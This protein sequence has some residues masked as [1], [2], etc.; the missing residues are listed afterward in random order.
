MRKNLQTACSAC[1]CVLQRELGI[2]DHSD[3]DRIISS[4]FRRI[5]IDLDHTPRQF[6]GPTNRWKIRESCA[7]GQHDIRS[8][9][10]LLNGLFRP[11][12]AEVQRVIGRDSAFSALGRQHG[13]A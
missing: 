9:D 3:L 7:D 2:P 11:P 5:D 4:D 6:Q 1:P 10:Q 13:S 8:S 12:I